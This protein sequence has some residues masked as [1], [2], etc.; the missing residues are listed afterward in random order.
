MRRPDRRSATL[1]G[2]TD[3]AYDAQNAESSSKYADAPQERDG[4]L[5]VRP[6]RELEK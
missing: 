6:A 3:L 1:A 5:G 2:V 4:N